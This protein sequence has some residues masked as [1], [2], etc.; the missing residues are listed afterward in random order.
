MTP[1][2][3]GWHRWGETAEGP[4]YRKRVGSRVLVAVVHTSGM[5]SYNVHE[6]AKRWR[7]GGT[8]TTV[9]VRLVQAT[10]SEVAELLALADL[11]DP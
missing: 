1:L 7:P 3:D 4:R 8:M 6:H 10:P 9:H 11:E 2:P 5:V